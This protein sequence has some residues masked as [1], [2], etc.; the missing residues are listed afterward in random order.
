RRRRTRSADAAGA[1][2]PAPDPAKP[3]CRGLPRAYARRSHPRASR[4]GREG[5]SMNRMP[6]TES[7]PGL[8]APVSADDGIR[9]VLRSWELRRI[10]YNLVLAAVTVYLVIRTWPHFRPALTWSSIP[11]LAVLAAIANVLYCAAYPVDLAFSGAAART[12]WRR[13]RW[14]LWLA[15]TLLA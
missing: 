2:T 9:E 13:C 15:G 8:S 4:A 14:A 5:R 11:K 12:L 10:L 7:V 1:Y 3:C 6:P